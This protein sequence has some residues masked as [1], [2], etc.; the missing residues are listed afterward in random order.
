MEDKKHS[1]KM[2]KFLQKKRRQE[3]QS[4]K[5][6]TDYSMAESE[7]LDFD[8]NNDLM[9]ISDSGD[10]DNE[11]HL[12]NYM[13]KH[14]SR[15]KANE[16]KNISNT[17]T[18]PNNAMA[19][20]IAKRLHSKPTNDNMNNNKTNA[21]TKY[22]EKIRKNNN[23]VQMIENENTCIDCMSQRM[24][25]RGHSSNSQHEPEE[26][27][28]QPE[29][30]YFSFWKKQG[31]LIMKNSIPSP[32]DVSAKDI[33]DFN[34][35][36]VW[37]MK[38]P[39][40][41]CNKLHSDINFFRICV[42]KHAKVNSIGSYLC[43]DCNIFLRKPVGNYISHLVLYHMKQ[44]GY[45]CQFKTFGN[46]GDKTPV[47]CNNVSCNTTKAGKHTLEEHLF[48]YIDTKLKSISNLVYTVGSGIRE[49]NKQN[50]N[51]LNRYKPLT[52]KSEKSSKYYSFRMNSNNNEYRYSN[53]NS[54]NN[55]N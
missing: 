46:Y 54:N 8:I 15:I 40:P 50:K 26:K 49:K 13:T 53:S 14:V 27:V 7:L 18:R 17:N 21:M 48:F 47:Q 10:K 22:M 6:A 12:N 11:Y 36:N 20:I 52:F 25:C 5:G 41:Y 32:Y 1:N 55:S 16:N 3:R 23:N 37:I 2:I 35:T 43:I 9:E 31:S 45:Y 42:L 24:P 44:T 38:D 30:E 28:P 39:C 4:N 51:N 34:L 29:Q 19:R 33:N